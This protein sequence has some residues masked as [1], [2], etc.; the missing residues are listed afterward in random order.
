VKRPTLTVSIQNNPPSVKVLDEKL[1]SDYMIPQDPK[2]DKKAILTALK[3]GMEVS[4]A[5]LQQTRGVRIR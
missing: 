5:E 2:L 3:E 4:G 1:L